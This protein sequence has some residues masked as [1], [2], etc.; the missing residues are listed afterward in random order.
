MDTTK[1]IRRFNLICD[2]LIIAENSKAYPYYF[3]IYNLKTKDLLV[4]FAMRGK[5]PGEF[6]SAKYLSNTYDYTNKEYFHIVDVV[7]Q[8]VSIFN[9][10]S[11]LNFKDDYRPSQFKLPDGMINFSPL[12]NGSYVFY[13]SFYLDNE[14]YSNHN[15]KI[16]LF[17]IRSEKLHIEN[18]KYFTPNVSSAYVLVSRDRDRIFIAERHRDVIDIYDKELQHIK[19]LKGPDFFDPQVFLRFSNHISFK[20]GTKDGGYYPC[21]STKDFVYL[22]YRGPKDLHNPEIEYP[23]VEVFKFDWEGNPIDRYV[24]DRFIY[25][26]SVSSDEKE[27]YGTSYN[28]I[29]DP[30][31]VRFSLTKN[32]Q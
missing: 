10:D 3:G 24:L 14:K 17:D 19:T 13:N 29:G 18:F 23:P 1:Y 7:S 31:L 15:D 9:L 28:S 25:T 12:I 4:E 11:L 8:K 21:Y 20:P 16:F 30:V 2:S 22:I 5:G 26:I 32:L 6:L 27:I